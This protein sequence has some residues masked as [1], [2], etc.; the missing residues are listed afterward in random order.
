MKT[1]DP[2]DVGSKPGHLPDVAWALFYIAAAIGSWLVGG[3]S[4]RGRI[5]GIETIGLLWFVSSLLALN[6]KQAIGLV[7]LACG[8]LPFV[9]VQALGMRAPEAR[10]ACSLG[11]CA[12]SFP[13]ACLLSPLRGRVTPAYVLLGFLLSVAVGV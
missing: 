11:V 13:L 10:L 9:C 12:V 8:F 4:G 3:E 1:V 7:G 2:E 5:G 6:S